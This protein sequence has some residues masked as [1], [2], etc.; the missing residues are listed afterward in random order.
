MSENVIVGGSVPRLSSH[1]NLTQNLLKTLI[2]DVKFISS[3]ILGVGDSP[4]EA[5][6]QERRSSTL[7]GPAWSCPEHPAG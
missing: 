4:K 1:G 6:G 7:H 5:Q 2:T 3:Q